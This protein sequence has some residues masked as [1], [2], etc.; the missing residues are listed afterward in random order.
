[1]AYPYKITDIDALESA[2]PKA[3][4]P[5]H[6]VIKKKPNHTEIGRLFRAS[7]VLG[8]SLPGVEATGG[9]TDDAPSID[10]T[11]DPKPAESMIQ[12]KMADD[13]KPKPSDI[14]SA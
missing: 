6:V 12:A 1:M 2:H 11:T 7:Q 10:V 13:K 8:V 5:E 14:L 4:T 9:S 3:V